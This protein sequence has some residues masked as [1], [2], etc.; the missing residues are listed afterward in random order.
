MEP[1]FNRIT[2]PEIYEN[3]RSKSQHNSRQ[4]TQS[5]CRIGPE[6]N[7][8]TETETKRKKNCSK[9]PEESKSSKE[10][11]RNAPRSDSIHL[12]T[13][14]TICPENKI[15]YREILLNII[16]KEQTWFET[17][18][19]W[20]TEHRVLFKQQDPDPQKKPQDYLL[21]TNEY[22]RCR[23]HQYYVFVQKRQY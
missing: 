22:F 11:R 13:R 14:E 5:R 16:R 19:N 4:R 7:I 15:Q 9:T 21:Q 23:Y 18:I 20:K 10:V 12:M 2:T 3:N 8:K 6:T 17:K 1:R